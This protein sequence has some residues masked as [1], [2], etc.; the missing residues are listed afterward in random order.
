MLAKVDIKAAYRNVPIHPEDRHL[1]GMRWRNRTY[2]DKVLPFG[3]R[4]APIIFTAVADALQ[5]LIKQEGVDFLDHYLDDYVTMGIA[6]SNECAENVRTIER[7]CSKTGI[8][9]EEEKKEGPATCIGF[10]GMEI[11]TMA[12][13]VR[14]PADKLQRL[15]EL[16]QSWA[17]RKAGKKR[18]LLSLLGVLNHACKAVWQGR[19][20]LRRLI[21]LASSV[22]KLDHFVCLNASAQSDICWWHHFAESWNGISML[23]EL[24]YSHPDVTLTSDASGN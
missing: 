18:E 13:Q 9:I 20:F 8:P 5:W 6:G 7:V 16:T 1:V 23:T 14:L 11:D 15:R 17:G 22:R 3:L 24:K 4:S 10:L 21:D 19:S 2:I 12:M